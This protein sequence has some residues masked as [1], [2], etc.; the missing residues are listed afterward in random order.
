MLLWIVCAA[1]L[2]AAI[3][4]LRTAALRRQAARLRMLVDERTAELQQANAHLE[5]LSL[6]DELTGIAN[7]RY[8]QR[9]LVEDW[10]NA[11]EEQQPLALVLIDLDHFKQ[12]NDRHGHPAGDAALVQTARL[13]ARQIRRSGDAPTRASDIVARI[14]GEEFAVLL[15]KTGEE[16]AVRVAE[17][18]RAGIAAMEVIA[19]ETVTLTASCGVA[20]MVPGHEDGWSALV[21][22]ADAALYAAKAAGR[23]CVQA[24]GDAGDRTSLAV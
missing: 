18:L 1:G 4:R 5:R 6:I 9:L 17:T 20:A 22:R 15:A 8:F 13:L 21:E 24:A 11:L 2:I 23:N 7:R 3:V 12:L 10:R 14:G 19:G 16:E